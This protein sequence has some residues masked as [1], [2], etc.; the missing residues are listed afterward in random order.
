MSGVAIRITRLFDHGRCL[1]TAV[2][3]GFFGEVS[4]L[5]GIEDMRQAVDVLVAAAPDAIHLTVGQA[6]LLQG[7]PDWKR[8][9]LALR[10]DVANVYGK[11]LPDRMF[12]IMI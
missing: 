4:F 3:H 2:D 8:P 6:R 5:S 12:S 11:V 7:V 1:D 9:A 10:T